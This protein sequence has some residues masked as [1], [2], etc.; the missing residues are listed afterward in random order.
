MLNYEAVL[1]NLIADLIYDR[2]E[3][4]LADDGPD[5][6]ACKSLAEEIVETL[7]QNLT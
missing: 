7:E 2:A 5:E 1:V 4:L 6:D 3:G